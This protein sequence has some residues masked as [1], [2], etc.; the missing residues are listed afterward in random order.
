MARKWIVQ[1]EGN[2]HEVQAEYGAFFSYGS[3]KAL[4]DGKVV[5]E[6]GLSAWGMIPKQRIFE[7]AGKK[8]TLRRKGLLVLNLELSVPEATKVTRVK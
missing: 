4:V 8:A 2:K 7:I 3:G 6:W 1:I 5:D